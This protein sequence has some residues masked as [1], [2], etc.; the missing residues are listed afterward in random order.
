[1]KQLPF[2]LFIFCIKVYSQSVELGDV[3]DISNTH[4][5][6]DNKEL[7]V[8]YSNDSLSVCRQINLNFLG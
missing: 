5:D 8:F 1:M 6:K 4:F 2:L 3:R 7:Y